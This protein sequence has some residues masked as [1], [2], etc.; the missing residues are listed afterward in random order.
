[1]NLGKN[2]GIGIYSDHEPRRNDGDPLDGTGRS[3]PRRVPVSLMEHIKNDNPILDLRLGATVC[4]HRR[5]PERPENA[6]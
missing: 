5:S 3:Y 2:L 6:T 4:C 1:M